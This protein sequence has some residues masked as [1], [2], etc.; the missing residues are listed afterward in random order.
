[1][2]DLLSSVLDAHGGL[3]RWRAFDMVEAIFMFGGQL[4]Q[5][6]VS[7]N[8]PANPTTGPTSRVEMS[9]REQSGTRTDSTGSGQRV[10]YSPDR[11][12][13]ENL[14]GELLSERRVPREAFAGHDLTTPWDLL[15]LGYFAGYTQWIYLN[16]PFIFTLPGVA[17][18]EV[19]P[20]RKGAERWRA[21][22]VTL[23]PDIASHTAVQIFYYNEDFLQRRHDYTLD[24]AGGCNVAHFTDDFRDASGLRLPFR[25]RAYLCDSD[26]DVLRDRLLIWI[27][28]SQ[29]H[30]R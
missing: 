5:T 14:D 17:T 22:R 29:I 25:R 15:H 27:D 8:L 26:Y 11:V 20:V 2:T 21:L 10:R 3:A 30:F 28:Y 13:I 7:P 23:P 4:V 6:K 19:D 24:V 1:M 18:E 9:T 12:A 16:A